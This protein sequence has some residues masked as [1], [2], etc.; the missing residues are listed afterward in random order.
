MSLSVQWGYYEAKQNTYTLTFPISFNQRALSMCLSNSNNGKGKAVIWELGKESASIGND[1]WENYWIAVGVQQW[2]NAGNSGGSVNVT[3]P[4]SFTKTVYQIQLTYNN[5]S[6]ENPTYEIKDTKSFRYWSKYGG[7]KLW[8][9]IG[10][11]QW[12]TNQPSPITFPLRFASKCLTVVPQLQ[13]SGDSGN[14]SKNRVCVSNLTTN[15]FA[16][17][18]PQSTYNYIAIGV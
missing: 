6:Y 18:Y 10:A 12:G 1:T 8:L 11:Q 2:G 15:G 4:V 5:D 7:N 17:E 14:M 13:A 16:I 3:F 9:A